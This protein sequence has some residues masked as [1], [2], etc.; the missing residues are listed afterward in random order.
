MG[1]FL[2]KDDT[3]RAMPRAGKYDFFILSVQG[4]VRGIFFYKN[5]T[6]NSTVSTDLYQCTSTRASAVPLEIHKALPVTDHHDAPWSDP[7]VL[8]HATH[9]TNAVVGGTVNAPHCSW[10]VAPPLCRAVQAEDRL[11]W[12]IR[13]FIAEQ[14]YAFARR[15]VPVRSR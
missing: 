6:I 3:P 4:V 15:P 1:L 14:A 13:G 8:D 5:S 12:L 10:S 7:V 9:A 2:K 11:H